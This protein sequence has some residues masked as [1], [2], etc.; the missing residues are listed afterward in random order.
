M[1]KKIDNTLIS[2]LKEITGAENVLTEPEQTI[3]YSHDE[4]TL[5]D[6]AHSPDVVV[7][8]GTAEEAA[9]ILKLAQNHRIPVTARGAATG[10]CG[11][12][13]PSQGGI[14]LSL[15]RMNRIIDIDDANQM[16]VVEA[17]VRLMDFY[18]AVK[19]A[20]LFFPPHPG[21]ESAMMG[22]LIAT[23]AGGAR[24]VKY[25]VIRNYIRGM[26]VVL[27]SGKIIRLG[28]KIMK[29]STGYNLLN[30][31]I[32]SEGTLGIVTRAVIQ[33]MPPA[34]ASRSLI[35]PYDSLEAAI[36]SVPLMI[37]NKILPL[38]VEFI[39]REVI[40]RTEKLLNK[41][42]PCSMGKVYLL[43]ILDASS[44]E[45]MD[46]LSQDV[47]EICLEKEALDVF[48]ADNPQKQKQVLDIRSKLYESI[49]DNNVET[50]DIVVPRGEIAGHVKKVQEVQERCGLWL[51]TYGH[52]ADGNVHTHIMNVR[53]DNG[54]TIPLPEKE[55]KEK[56][57]KIRA[58]LYRDCQERGGMIS[59]EHGIGLVKKPYLS[60][61]I[62]NEQIR[63][64]REIK[65]VFD[66]ENILNPDKIFT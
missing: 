9:G 39:P 49:K 52:A 11:G 7:R 30:L 22:G 23:N 19:E 13:V 21:D 29:S 17:G 42:W 54:E 12:C 58:D 27:A 33:L 44:Q 28:G 34:P 2:K 14:V 43:V 1:V 62:D 26:D 48:V 45:D 59:G 10:L 37:R 35:I 3:D 40:V 50:L 18:Q 57:G 24:A 64:M 4:F 6:I 60:Y 53:Y 20:G 32:G 8:P 56:L 66:P 5:D 63:L 61:V 25:G 55:W 47:A 46:K 38:A 31:F 15:E 51:P 36:E 16:A 65:K 41:K